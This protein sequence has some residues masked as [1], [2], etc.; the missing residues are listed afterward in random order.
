MA[1]T[2]ARFAVTVKMSL[3]YIS[4]GSLTAPSGNAGVGVVGVKSRSTFSNARAKS[5][6]MRPR[7][8]CALR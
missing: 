6:A 3:R 4:Y 8:C 5:C 1:G 2:P 7:T